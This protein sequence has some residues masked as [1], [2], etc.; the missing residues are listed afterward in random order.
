MQERNSPDVGSLT[1]TEAVWYVSSWIAAV[2]PI[3]GGRLLQSTVAGRH[4][5]SVGAGKGLKQ[6]LAA[7]YCQDVA[8]YVRAREAVK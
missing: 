5:R 8:V 3:P 1:W 2:C 4:T 6:H 7:P